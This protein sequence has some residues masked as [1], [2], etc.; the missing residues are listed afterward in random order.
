MIGRAVIGLIGPANYCSFGRETDPLDGMTWKSIFFDFDG[1]I[2]RQ[3]WWLSMIAI[4][5]ASLA[6]SFLANPMSWYLED[7]SRSGPNIAETLFSIAFLIPE[8]AITVKRFNDRDWPQWLP[9]TYAMAY[10]C[11]IL[12][13]HHGLLFASGRP[14][15]LDMVLV[16]LFAAMV[17]IVIIDNGLLRGTAGPNRY[18]P[19][20]LARKSQAPTAPWRSPGHL[21]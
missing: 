15:I 20:P 9:Y 14:A 11:F 7:Q 3:Q 16:G 2:S 5:F 12:L 10:L 4:L 6:L 19:D 21:Q 8:T 18:G 1:R 13:D 17:F